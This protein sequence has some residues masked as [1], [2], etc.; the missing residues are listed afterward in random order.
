MLCERAGSSRLGDRSLLRT[1]ASLDQIKRHGRQYDNARR[2]VEGPRTTSSAKLCSDGCA[3]YGWHSTKP[4]TFL[5][6]VILRR[7]VGRG[8]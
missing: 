5:D 1:G 6:S 7:G 3:L 2:S 8:C 4:Q